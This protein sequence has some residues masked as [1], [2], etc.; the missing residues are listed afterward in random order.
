MCKLWELVRG[1]ESVMAPCGFDW[2]IS[3][4]LVG[5]F[6]AKEVFVSQMGIIYAVEGNETSESLLA[7]PEAPTRAAG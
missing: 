2:R 6:A 5:A 1:L 4:A 3:A 7:Q